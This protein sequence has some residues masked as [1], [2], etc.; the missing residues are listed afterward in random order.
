[1]SKNEK[2]HPDYVIRSLMKVD[3]S[4]RNGQFLYAH[5]EANKLLAELIRKEYDIEDDLINEIESSIKRTILFLRP[6][7]AAYAQNQSSLDIVK[8]SSKCKKIKQP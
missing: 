2:K 5:R 6:V 4:I 7:I 8:R 3:S 1:M